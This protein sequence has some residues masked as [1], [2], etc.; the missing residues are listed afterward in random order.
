[1][2]RGGNSAVEAPQATKSSAWQGLSFITTVV[3]WLHIHDERQSSAI[4]CLLAFL[5]AGHQTCHRDFDSAGQCVDVGHRI[6][7]GEDAEEQVLGLCRPPDYADRGVK[8][9]ASEER[10]VEQSA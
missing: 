6:I 8:V 10:W 2:P 1:M 5:A 9:L 7:V 4:T 3:V